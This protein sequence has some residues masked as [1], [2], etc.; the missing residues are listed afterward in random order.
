[1]VTSPGLGG[2]ADKGFSGRSKIEK[3]ERRWKQRTKHDPCQVPEK[4]SQ[5]LAVDG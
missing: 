2:N 1:M 4:K 3:R 5:H